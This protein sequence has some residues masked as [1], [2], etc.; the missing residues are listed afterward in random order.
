MLIDLAEFTGQRG[1]VHQTSKQTL[2]ASEFRVIY[3]RC[4]HKLLRQ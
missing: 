4:K 2:L 1:F 3:Q